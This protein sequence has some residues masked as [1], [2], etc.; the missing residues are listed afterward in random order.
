LPLPGGRWPPD[1]R[2]MPFHRIAVRHRATPRTFIAVY[3][4]EAASQ[5]LA[6][7]GAK[8][9]FRREYPDRAVENY[10]FERDRR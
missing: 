8:E 5:E 2:G 4:V 9:R 3:E 10:S 7:E 1:D 6:I